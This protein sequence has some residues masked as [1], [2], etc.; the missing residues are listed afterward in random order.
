MEKYVNKWYTRINKI[1]KYLYIYINTI[2][3]NEQKI[4]LWKIY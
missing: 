3:I 1:I 2:E 4:Y